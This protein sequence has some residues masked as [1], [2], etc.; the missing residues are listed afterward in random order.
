MTN[1]NILP[2]SNVINV[3]IETTPQGLTEKNVNSLA[4]FTNENPLS[5]ISKPYAIYVSPAQVAADYGTNSVTAAMANAI[6]S[7]VP[8]VLSGTGRLVII[9]LLAS[10][11]ATSGNIATA[12][13]SANLAAIIAVTNGDIKV[14]IDSVVYNIANLNFTGCV[15]WADVVGVLQAQIAA[16][17]VAP[18]TNGFT[19]TSKKVGS[20]SSVALAA[21]SGGGTDLSGAGFFNAG[22]EVATAGVNSSGETLLAA[23]QRTSGLVGYVPFM[24]TLNLEDAVI[25][26]TANGVQAL[27]NLYF[28]HFSS[29]TDLA[30]AITTIQQASNTKTRCLLYLTTQSSANL[31]KAAYAGRGCSVDFTGSNTSQTMNLKALAT[32]VPDPNMTETIYQNAVT[33]GADLYVSYDGVPSVV[34]NGANNYF[35]NVYSDLALKFGLTTAGFDYLRQTNTKVPQTEKGM[36]GLKAAY[37][38]VMQQ[39]VFNGCLAPGAWNS[40]ETFGDPVIFNDNVSRYGFYIFSF[41][42]AQ[43]NVSDRDNRIAPLVQIAAKRAGAIHKSNVIVIVND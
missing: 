20:A 15:T 31:F 29:P 25:E 39:F 33:A 41:P 21:F 5:I 4:L 38:Q 37:A 36:N 27:D 7:Q 24:S 19:I 12:N 10:V 6:F 30:G 43:Q 26:T 9:P 11:S 35:D 34:S 17:N 2:V 3:T 14:T 28:Q 16:G 8:N 32:I 13:L 18:A 40:A 23:I 1:Q 22:S 42:I